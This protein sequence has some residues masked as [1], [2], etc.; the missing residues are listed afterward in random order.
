MASHLQDAHLPS[1]T[2]SDDS[3]D[4]HERTAAFLLLVLQQAALHQAQDRAAHRAYLTRHD[5][6]PHPR[7]Q[8]PFQQVLTGEVD[9]AYIATMGLDVKTFK[10]L[11]SAGFEVAWN[12]TPIP[13]SEVAPSSEPRPH[14]RSLDA[15]GGLG[16]LLY[17]LNSTMIDKTLSQLFALV[18]STITRYRE[19]A[20]HLLLRTLQHIPE[21]RILWPKDDE[22]AQLRDLVVARHPLL[23]GAFGSVDGLNL[24]TATSSD[25]RWQNAQYNGWLH[26]HFTSNVLVFSASGELIHAAINAPGSWHDARVA[27]KVYEQLEIKTPEGFYL[28]ADT[29]FPHNRR[30]LK[31]KIRTPLKSGAR[32]TQQELQFT[33]Q[34]VSYRQ[35][36]E[37]GMRAIQGSFGRLR[38]PLDA[39]DASARHLLLETIFRLHQIRVR[40]VGINQLK[41][42]YEPIWTETKELKHVWR[43]L[44]TMLFPEIR[45]ADRVAQ[46][47]YVVVDE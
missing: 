12:T 40:L 38:L 6:L 25:E 42:V 9:R 28:A 46:F 29:A 8:T 37:W 34:L 44:Q 16:L 17:W 1:D 30:T 18:P 22:F 13:R 5:L 47:H 43:N 15:A 10:R 45:R 2:E 35:S 11:L 7:R 20:L 3:S 21:G 26:G 23:N 41:N 27:S 4:E 31:S 36:A 14:Q 24:P 19:F 32:A 39:N 33:D